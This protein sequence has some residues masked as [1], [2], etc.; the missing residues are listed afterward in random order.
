[1]LGQLLHQSP[2]ARPSVT[3][4]LNH[5]WL[6]VGVS[7][8]SVDLI[9]S[10]PAAVNEFS[11]GFALRRLALVAAARETDD[12]EL[13]SLRSFFQQLEQECEGMLTRQ[14]LENAMRRPG[15]IGA[16]AAELV[17]AFDAVD[18]NSS[19]LL[20]WSE[21]LAISLG[22]AGI[23]GVAAASSLRESEVHKPG[24]PLLREDA[25]WRAF[26]LLSRGSGILSCISLGRLMAPTETDFVSIGVGAAIDSG[27]APKHAELDRLVREYDSTGVVT[28]SDFLGLFLPRVPT[29][30]NSQAGA[31]AQGASERRS[32]ARRSPLVHV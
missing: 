7:A 32:A 4:L 17:H 10:M 9:R 2:C 13:S 5:P 28:S 24:M 3:K 15:Y 6:A 11:S 29:L 31:S 22:A 23:S 21:I 1:M 14:A 25:C 8:V 20:N 30:S 19:G 16:T 27:Q 26:D 18:I 12:V